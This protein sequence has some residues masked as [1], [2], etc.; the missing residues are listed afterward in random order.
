[1]SD[2]IGKTIAGYQIIEMIDDSG[3]AEVYKGFQP[4]ENRYV[5]VKV[6][7]PDVQNDQAAVLSFTNYAQQA[8]GMQHPNILPVLDSGQED[9]ANYL[10]TPFM[11]SRSAADNLSSYADLNQAQRFVSDT[12]PGLEYIY[13]QGTVHGNLRPTN[14]ILGAQ[15]QPQ[16]A[17]FGMAPSQAPASSP[18]NS[19]EQVQGGVVD[20]RTD[21]YA[22]GALLYTLLAGK[23]PDPGTVVNLRGVRPDVPQSVEQ[24]VLKAMAQNP[25]QRFQSPREFQNSL[26]NALQPVAPQPAAA[27]A[28]PPPQEKKGTNW[29]AILLGGALVIIMCL[30]VGLVGPKIVDYLNPTQP[31]SVE[32]IQSPAAQP[33]AQQPPEQQPP[34]QPPPE[35]QPPAQQPPEQQPPDQGAPEQQ[36]A[37][38]GGGFE[39]P[40][41]GGS[42]GMAGAFALMGGAYTFKRRKRSRTGKTG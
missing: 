1:M 24:V 34:A 35:Q 30:C 11:E 3:R 31:V 8:A 17:D 37:G 10:V 21:V 20:Q 15:R 25:D 4:D 2:L 42:I 32:P 22:L 41:C 33:P 13:S 38:E 36:P 39:F 12:I 26:N 27:P 18:Y 19:P 23:A 40:S 6:L 14:I 7:K 9:G 5:A 16:L 29:T 28:Q